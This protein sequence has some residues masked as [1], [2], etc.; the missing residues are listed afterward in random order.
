M[1]AFRT[2][3]VVALLACTPLAAVAQCEGVN[4]VTNGS[5]VSVEGEA[6]TAPGWTPGIT[7]D[8]NDENGPLNCT[9]GYV[10]TGV[11]VASSDGGTWQNIYGPETIEQT[12]QLMMGQTYTLQFEYAAQ[13]I[14][15]DTFTYYAAP[16]GVS[17]SMNNMLVYTTPLDQSQF[18][19]ELA[20]YTFTAPAAGVT[21]RFGESTLTNYVGID[22]ICLAPDKTTGM[23][24]PAFGTV[25]AYPNPADE[26]VSLYV[27]ARSANNVRLLNLLGQPMPV[28]IAVAGDRA[29]IDTSAMPNGIYFIASAERGAK[30]VRVV[31][32]HR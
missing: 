29:S 26:N 11:P 21:I 30:P 12:V 20:S 16:T 24:E 22:G 23:G 7:P 19:W 4:F 18:S 32:D 15:A 5:F 17:V 3:V 10:W 13:G 31:V 9:P 2:R 6:I 14:M 25:G 8:V 1:I 28:A 27:G